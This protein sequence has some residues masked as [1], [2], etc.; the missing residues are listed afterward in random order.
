MQRSFLWSQTATVFLLLAGMSA[1]VRSEEAFFLQGGEK[2]I[3]FGD[4]ITQ[5]GMYVE[6][7]EAFLATR[8]PD[9]RFEVINDHLRRRREQCVSFFLAGDGVHPNPTGHWLMAQQLLLA[10]NAPALCSEVEIDAAEPKVVSGD[11]SGLNKIDRELIFTWTTPMP[12]PFDP[13]WDPESIAVEHMAER[14]NRHR[15]KV[16][17]LPPGDYEVIVGDEP[18]ARL[19]AKQLA[20][21]VDLAASKSFPTSQRADGILRLIQKRQ[22]LLYQ[23]WRKSLPDA[24]ASRPG[25]GGR[26]LRDIEETTQEMAGKIR[27][28]SQPVE[29]RI[30]IR[31]QPL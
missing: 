29:L 7:V 1:V 5:A 8:F 6:Y 9:K 22:R 25:D 23:A 31:P 4:S 17:P 27:Q 15:L 12:M 14:L 20:E 11:V 19:S 28:L 16:L 10:W 24:R 26:A 13:R 3:F 2:V 18:V 30:R 21:G